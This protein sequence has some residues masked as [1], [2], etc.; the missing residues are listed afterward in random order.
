MAYHDLAFVRGVST[1]ERS[2]LHIAC[3]QLAYKASKLSKN[4]AASPPPASATAAADGAMA[5]LSKPA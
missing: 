3:R 5:N 1:P 4:L 2:L